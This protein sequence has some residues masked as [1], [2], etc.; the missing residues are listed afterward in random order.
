MR[1]GGKGGRA[2]AGL[3]VRKGGRGPCGRAGAAVP[4]APPN[5]LAE[6]S[7]GDL[8]TSCLVTSPPAP[9]YRTRV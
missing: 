2:A 3:S 9:G 7:S 6:P 1:Q 8:V 4:G 5:G